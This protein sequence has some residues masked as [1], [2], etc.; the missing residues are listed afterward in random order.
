M[1]SRVELT[2]SDPRWVGAWWIGFLVSSIAGFSIAVVMG[3]FA[4]ELPGNGNYQPS[5]I[6]LF[7]YVSTVQLFTIDA[8]VFLCSCQEVPAGE[9]DTVV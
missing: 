9:G 1:F 6:G 7:I 2:P 5:D 4:R 8:C 3:C